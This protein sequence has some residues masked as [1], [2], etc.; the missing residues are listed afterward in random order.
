MAYE[1]KVLVLKGT[2]IES[3]IPGK[4]L[5]GIARIETENGVSELHLSLINLPKE[6]TGE[7]F[8][9]VIDGKKKSY[10]FELGVRPSAFA[11]V[12]PDLIDANK[13]L[14]VGIYAVNSGIPLT[15][16][17]ARS[18][19]F[20]FSLSDFKKLVAEKC[21]SAR[22]KDQ[23]KEQAPEPAPFPNENPFDPIAPNEPSPIK[24]PY[25]PAPNPDPNVTPP[26]EFNRLRGQSGYD[27]EAVA[28]VN[29]YELDE[30]IKSKLDTLK[31]LR[32][33]NSPFEN[34]LPFSSGEKETFKTYDSAHRTQDEEGARER[35]TDERSDYFSTVKEELICLFDKY[36]PE[37][38]LMKTFHDSKW[39]KIHYSKDK[40]YVVGLIKE[41]G[42]EKYICYGVPAVYSPKPPQELKG[43]CSFIPLSIFNMKGDGYWMMFQDAISGECI[44]IE[45]V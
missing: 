44:H 1:K 14:A 5:L 16:M 26:D 22:R 29:Y 15:I 37:D 25:P 28:T 39:A 6:V 35:K 8:A 30:D 27:D 24:P 9:L 21:I 45:T 17:F 23:K 10:Y 11:K 42:K 18:D 40:Y 4:P 41:D 20:N 31:E 34:E 19:G 3:A 32:N 7:Y 43:F 12:F 33:G 36:P 13:G 2:D 38:T